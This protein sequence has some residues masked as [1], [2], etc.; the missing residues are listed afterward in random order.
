MFLS[1]AGIDQMRMGEQKISLLVLAAGMGSRYGGLKQLDALGPDG[2]T[3]LEY[4]IYDAIKAGFTK[5]VFVVRDFFKEDFA[6]KVGSKFK[7][8]IEVDY[9]CQEV[10]PSIDGMEDLPVREKPWGTSHAV[11]VA[12][13]LIHEPFAVINADDYYGQD[14]FGMIA[15]FLK[16]GISPSAY[17]MVGY[18]LKNTLSEKG[19]VNRGVCSASED[20][21]L[22]SIE[23]TLRIKKDESGEIT[24]DGGNGGLTN[25]TVVSMNFWGFHQYI[26]HHLE[27]GFRNFVQANKDNLKAEYFIPLI[28]DDLIRSHQATVKILTSTDRW[29]GVT[30]KEDAEQVRIAM[31]NFAD[32]GKYPQPL[33]NSSDS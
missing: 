12:K 22:V 6:E 25:D 19:H 28:V 2:E 7:E 23:E 16:N 18:Q 26:F 5:V 31:Q 17:A 4:S 20:G 9:V 33:W 15:D 24:Y 1:L 27:E 21:F 14:C 32:E 10:N 8:H 30:Y 13:E 3:I 29:F 11:L